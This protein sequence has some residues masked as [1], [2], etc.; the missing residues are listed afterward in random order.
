[1]NDNDNRI[2]ENPKII[3]FIPYS[4]FK[5]NYKEAL[6]DFLNKNN[7]KANIDESS[8]STEIYKI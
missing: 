2:I 5:K 1:M 4:F 3:R 8:N 6:V 7:L